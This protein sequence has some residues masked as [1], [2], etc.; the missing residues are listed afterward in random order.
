MA[1]KKS[2]KVGKQTDREVRSTSRDLPKGQT[3]S[4]KK[5]HVDIVLKKDVQYTKSSGFEEIDFLHCALPECDYNKIDLSCTFLGKKLGAPLL[6]TGMTGGYKDAE[7]INHSLA[8]AAEKYKL[9]FGVGSQ[10][11]MIESPELKKTYYVRDVAPSIPLLA[12]IGGVQLR[13][14]GIEKVS[15][16]V[17]GIEADAIAVHLNALQEITQ[18]EGDRDFTGVFAAIRQACEQLDVPVIV[19]ETGAG[20]SSDIA[21]KLRDIGVKYIDV[22]GAGG[23]SWSKV[24]Y[25][26]KGFTP[27]FENWG[28]PTVAAILMCRGVL[29]LIGSGGVREGIDAAKCIALG[30]DIAGAA[31]PFIKALEAGGNKLDALVEKWLTQMRACAFLTGSKNYQELKKAKIVFRNT[32]EA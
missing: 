18:P 27:G 19:K 15:S 9:A 28:I 8:E 20:I 26:R 14:Y 3:E 32:S 10:R 30:C 25:E 21:L 6:I 7:R 11:A 16:L 17:S 24:E 23:T 2:E 4:R 13:K 1:S 29:P 12:N 22:S 31:Y 5:D